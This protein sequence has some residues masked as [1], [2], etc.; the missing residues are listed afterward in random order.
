M[1]NNYIERLFLLFR[2]KTVNK[3]LSL[4]KEIKLVRNDTWNK[5]NDNNNNNIINKDYVIRIYFED[6]E[7]YILCKKNMKYKEYDPTISN[8]ETKADDYKIIN[9]GIGYITYRIS[10]GQIGLFY[11]DKK[12]QNCGLGK[13]IL[14]RAMEDIKNNGCNKVFAVTSKNHHFWANVFGSSFKWSERPDNSVT[15]SGYFLNLK[16]IF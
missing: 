2:S 4:F 13:Q 15:G 11:I 14:L 7:Q 1:L 8:F 9:K 10:T 3:D 5:N 12:Y 6:E 16:Y